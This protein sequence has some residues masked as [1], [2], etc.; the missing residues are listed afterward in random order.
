[1][2]QTCDV[3]LAHIRILSVEMASSQESEDIVGRVLTD[4]IA[5]RLS[6]F[7]SVSIERDGLIAILQMPR[8]ETLGS[9]V[10]LE[11]VLKSSLHFLPNSLRYVGYLIAG[12]TGDVIWNC[13]LDMDRAE[14]LTVSEQV[15]GQIADATGV[16][17]SGWEPARHS[18][19]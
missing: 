7:F 10:A 15:S 16:S 19:I 3:S 12:D 1:V 18:A 4:E 9:R 11:Y 13:S 17:L 2:G 6:R 5:V 8:D 14:I